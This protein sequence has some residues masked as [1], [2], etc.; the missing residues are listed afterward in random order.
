MYANIQ[1]VF[2]L[3]RK[4]THFWKRSEKTT[5]NICEGK[6]TNDHRML[7]YTVFDLQT[8][9]K[10][11]SASAQLQTLKTFINKNMSSNL[12]KRIMY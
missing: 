8:T 4:G 9:Q 5:T 11:L 7:H 2:T 1:F 6:P 3:L 10:H 12:L